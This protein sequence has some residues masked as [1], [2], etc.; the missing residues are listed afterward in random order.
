MP[1]STNTEP[2]LPG[3]IPF[4]QYLEQLE[5]MFQHNKFA[6]DD[7]KSSFLAVCGTEV[8]SRLKLLFPGRDFKDLTYKE[9]TESL[10]RHYDKIDSDVIH[11]F[12]FWTRRQGQ[13]EKAV[14][15]VLDVKNLAE[16]CNFGDFKERAIRDVL[17]IGTYDRQLQNRLFD[18]EDLTAS[19]A[20]KIIVN[21]EIASDRTNSLQ[22]DEGSR[23]GVIARLG[24]RSPIKSSRGIGYRARSRSDSR[25][26]SVRFR[27]DGYSRYN[28]EYDN[29]SPGKTTYFCSYCKKRGHTKKYCFRL[30]DKKAS[31]STQS[32]N[33]VDSSKPNTSDSSGLFK[34]LATDLEEN[35]DEEDFACLM[36]SS[37]KKI[38]EPCYVEAQIESRM[39]T[40]EVDCGSAESVISEELFLRNFR[41]F[42]LEVCNKRLVV[43]DGKRLQVLGKADVLVQLNG[44]R[45]QLPLIVLRCNNEFTPLMGRS[46]LDIFFGDWRQAFTHQASTTRV[47]SLKDEE[48]LNIKRKFPSVFD[49]DLSRPIKGYVGD[50][51]L[52]DDKPIFRK[53]YDVPLRLKQKV[54]DCLDG[55]EKD[56][57][58]EPVETS[59][60]ASPVVVVVKKDQGIRLVIDCKVT[61]NK[62]IVS[63]SYPLPLIQDIFA[64]LSGAKYFCS[65]DLAGAYTQLLLSERSKKFMVINTIK[66]LYRYNRL[67]QGAASSAAIFQRIMDQ[68]LQGLDDVVCYLDDVL[69]CGKTM[70]ECR[71]KL[72]LVLDRLAKA[73]IKVKLE[74]CKFFVKEL[75]YLGHIITDKGLLPCPD[76]IKT[77]REAKAPSN[78]TELKAFLGLVTYYAKFIPNL[79]SRISCLYSLLKKNVKYN[80]SAECDRAFNECKHC[81]L[82]PK[83]LEYFDPEKP[84]VIVTDACSYGLGG[85]MAHVVNG[86]ERPVCFA[87]FSLNNAQKNY[88]ILHLEALA[89]VSTVKKFHKFLYGKSFTIYTDHKPLIGIFGKE[90]K[91][92]ISVTRL[93]RYLRELAIYD[94]EIIYRPSNKMGNADFCSRFPLPEMV[95]AN[96][97]VEY[98][99][100]LNF[101]N[102][103]PINYKEIAIATETDDFTKQIRRFIDKGWPERFD[104]QFKNAYAIHQ[105]M[106]IVDGC[107]LFHDRVMIPDSMKI[108]V[109]KLLHMNHSGISKIKQLARRC[110][111][112]FGLDADI[113]KF[114]KS[115]TICNEMTAV[116]KPAKYSQWIPTTKP[117]SRIH[118]DFFHFDKKIFLLVVDSYTKW[119]ELEHMA[120]GTDAKKVIKIFLKIFARFGLPD[121]LVTD[122]GP[123]FNSELFVKFFEKQGITVMKSPPYHPESNGQAERMVRLIKDVF[124]KFIRDPE[125]KKLDAEEQIA[126]FLINYRN[127]CLGANDKFPSEKLLSYKPKVLL[128]LIHP[129]SNFKKN[130]TTSLDETQKVEQGKN[131]MSDPFACMKF[132][133]LIYYRNNNKTDIRKWLPA[134]F[135]K[136]T[137]SN[138]LQVSLGGRVVLAHKRQL[139]LP[140]SRQKTSSRFVFHGESVASVPIE[141]PGTSGSYRMENHPNQA[142][143]SDASLRPAKRRREDDEEDCVGVF[144][145]DSESDFYGFAADSFVFGSLSDSVVEAQTE[146]DSIRRSARTVKKKRKEDY[147]YY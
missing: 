86:E 61:I 132:G 2:F 133:D 114:V 53:A 35:S 24:R 78:V 120:Y 88:P 100:S 93:Q 124:K 27:N 110:V 105:E 58:I 75:P 52:K 122:G 46:W 38:N 6:A 142:N 125:M 80:W 112:W 37:I 140:D 72:Y 91:T 63:N 28:R 51:V 102:E 116:T 92:S 20:E 8:F 74:K 131:E 11:S 111:F 54:L 60:W 138:I 81:L 10:K 129:K 67:P 134:K 40:M 139:K 146:K 113:E 7:Y 5:W 1:L 70:E 115:C 99:K 103:F 141:Q 65:L 19:K 64:T 13:H 118:A 23:L 15:F 22:R 136:R 36:I 95:P 18:E 32:V 16:Q 30:K 3:T 128:D 96:L 119:L 98:V 69:I 29:G 56:G 45:K 34:R 59:E 55:L 97:D 117:F 123:P 145:S 126:Y 44:L 26:R 107:I 106:E 48:L 12:K 89:I 90:G 71:A 76:K 66:G 57:I 17:V 104:K 144:S 31:K 33:F 137:S 73:N 84:V 4:A 25:N 50:L 9:I 147:L 68:V 94:Y 43:I 41:D 47:H 108:K 83:L 101:S 21:K 87:S 39:L 85:V 127:T 121:V 143:M 77:I 79:S 109:L 42:R 49:K 14:D 135:I 130:L 62:V 82:K